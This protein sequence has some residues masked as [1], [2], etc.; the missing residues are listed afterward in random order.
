M[1][2]EPTFSWTDGVSVL[3]PSWR[4]IH[5]RVDTYPS[6]LDLHVILQRAG[7]DGCVQ[8]P[9]FFAIQL[10]AYLVAFRVG[11]FCRQ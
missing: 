9:V 1:K 2:N 10:L 5:D 4:F 11:E 6:L 3:L 7:D 8:G